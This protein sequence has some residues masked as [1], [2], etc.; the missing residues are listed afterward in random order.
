MTYTPNV[1]ATRVN[2]EFVFVANSMDEIEWGTEADFG[3]CG[4]CGSS[5][6]TLKETL[7][8]GRAVCSEGDEYRLVMKDA[9]SVW[10]PLGF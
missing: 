5:E 8:G 2:D 4:A 10:N 9:A 6:W 1:V 7:N 3:Q